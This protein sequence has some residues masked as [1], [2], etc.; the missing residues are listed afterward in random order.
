MSP[1]A[2]THCDKVNR[3]GLVAV[4]LLVAV[5][6]LVMRLPSCH[7]SFWLDELH[8]A[9][10]VSGDFSAVAE[11]A[12]LG[13]QTTGY[14]HSLW[15]WHALVGS[16][17]L[18]M[19]LSSVI[20]VT[21]TAVLL[22]IGVSLQTRRIFAGMIS[23]GIVALDSNAVF[24]GC[25]L[26]PYA[27][28][29]LCAVLA[30]WAMMTWLDG[31]NGGGESQPWSLRGARW[32]LAALFFIC[33]AAL[34][35]PTSL[36][37]LFWLVPLAIVAAW[38]R[39]RLTLWRADGIAVVV[40]VATLGLLAAS[41]LPNSW[42][43][44]QQWKA[45]GHVTQITPLWYAWSWVPIVFVPIAIGIV[46]GLENKLTRK[47]ES[48]SLV[49]ILPLLAG[50]IGTISFFCASYFDLVPLWPPPLFC[51]RA[52]A[53]G[54]VCGSRQYLRVAGDKDRHWE[55]VCHCGRSF[56]VVV[57]VSGIACAISARSDS[58]TTARRRMA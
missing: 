23:G 16:D 47:S 46:G 24:F 14:F 35:H 56:V 10:T 41:S 17:E 39:G 58:P 2:H 38:F 18:R 32:R 43:H 33:V 51:C 30:T 40:V 13:N 37:V 9:W 50:A 1:D 12:A 28:V 55:V 25:E 5:I 6:S 15:I 36:G 8:S 57:L 31:G 52:A 3:G 27:A 4:A 34:L 26:R 19:R 45:F 20:L 49:G 53:A 44:R 7:E 42:E 54:L 48:E 11:R 29:M 21:L 22:V